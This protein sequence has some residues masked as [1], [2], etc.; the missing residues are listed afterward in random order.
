VNANSAANPK[1]TIKF[2]SSAVERNLVPHS[3]MFA[4]AFVDEK[5][6][7][8]SESCIRMVIEHVGST[9]VKNMPAKPY[10]DMFVD[11]FSSP[12]TRKIDD[13]GRDTVMKEDGYCVVSR[14]LLYFREVPSV[15][16]PVK[17]FFLHFDEERPHESALAIFGKEAACRKKQKLDGPFGHQRAV[18]PAYAYA[19]IFRGRLRSDAAMRV[20]YIAAKQQYIAD[21]N[22]FWSYAGRKCAFFAKAQE[23]NSDMQVYGYSRIRQEPPSS[24]LNLVSAII[25]EDVDEVR[26]LVWGGCVPL[27]TEGRWL[28]TTQGDGTVHLGLYGVTIQKLVSGESENSEIFKEIKQLITEASGG[29]K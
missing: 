29:Y 18:F 19:K 5:Q 22:G 14:G 12:E 10:I 23:E 20:R 13:L 4:Q 21:S 1:T 17:G 3:P 2:D 8:E 25:D 27:H 24:Q 28:A 15:S 9:A 26:R 6:R 11:P 16:T 7:L